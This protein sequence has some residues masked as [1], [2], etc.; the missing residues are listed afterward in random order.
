MGFAENSKLCLELW[1]I[2]RLYVWWPNLIMKPHIQNFQNI[3]FSSFLQAYPLNLSTITS[4]DLPAAEN[5][6]RETYHMGCWV[7]DGEVW[8]S[9]CGRGWDVHPSWHWHESM[10]DVLTSDFI[11]DQHGKPSH[12]LPLTWIKAHVGIDQI[13]QADQE[14]KEGDTGVLTWN[15]Q[16]ELCPGRKWK[17][18]LKTAEIQ[19][20]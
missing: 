19:G 9:I 6:S 15:S 12:T 20:L 2:V 18:R 3:L 10:W 7:W 8:R 4:H 17:T 14:A 5:I 11:A 16:I 13:E 1:A